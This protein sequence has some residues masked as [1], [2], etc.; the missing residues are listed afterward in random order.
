MLPPVSRTID[1]GNP[2]E[3][4]TS[5]DLGLW[6]FTGTVLTRALGNVLIFLRL[7]FIELRARTGRTDGQHA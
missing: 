4:L 2:F 3:I 6:H 7:S 5:V 1:S